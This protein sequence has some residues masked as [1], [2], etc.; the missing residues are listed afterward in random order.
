MEYIFQKMLLRLNILLFLLG[1]AVTS[2]DGFFMQS[3]QFEGLHAI[4]SVWM[5]SSC[6]QVNI[7]GFVMQSGQFWMASCNWVGL[8]NF[9]KKSGQSR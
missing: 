9:F 1:F 4:R 3:G 5:A 8:D 6:D 2:L 7:D